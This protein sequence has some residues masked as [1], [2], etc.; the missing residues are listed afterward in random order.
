MSGESTTVNRSL[1]EYY[2]VLEEAKAD[3]LGACFVLS[4]HSEADQR[5][6]LALFIAGFLRSIRFGLTHAHGGANAIQFNYLLQQG[7][8]HANPESGEIFINEMRARNA[9]LN[10][11]SE[12]IEI[13]EHGDYERAKQFTSSFCVTTSVINNLLHKLRKLPIDIR[14][15]YKTAQS[16]D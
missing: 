11:A 12:I 6:F 10:L 7:A 13:Q 14:I 9:I 5:T 16:G 15:R 2:S 4:M 3:A 8:F 1:R